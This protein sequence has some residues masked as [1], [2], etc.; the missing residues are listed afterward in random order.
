MYVPTCVSRPISGDQYHSDCDVLMIVTT[1]N[2]PY[3][4]PHRRILLLIVVAVY[5]RYSSSGAST[6][7][8]FRHFPCVF[9]VVVCN[10]DSYTIRSRLR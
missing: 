4:I 2:M 6:A 8:D 9:G 3:Q 5:L 10:W 1:V 7:K